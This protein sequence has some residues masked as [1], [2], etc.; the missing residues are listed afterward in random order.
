MKTNIF[1]IKNRCPTGP[2]GRKTV[3][4]CSSEALCKAAALAQISDE[5]NEVAALL[6][7]GALSY[8]RAAKSDFEA[9]LLHGFNRHLLPRVLQSGAAHAVRPPLIGHGDRL[10]TDG[11]RTSSPEKAVNP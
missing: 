4:L 10:Q 5:P 9:C 3:V 2:L 7:L 11:S 6:Q 1:W 8:L